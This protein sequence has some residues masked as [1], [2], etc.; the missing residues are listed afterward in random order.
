MVVFDCILSFEQVNGKLD[1][2]SRMEHPHRKTEEAEEIIIR[3]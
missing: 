3:T 1:G 2:Y